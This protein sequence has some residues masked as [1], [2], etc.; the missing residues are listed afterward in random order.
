MFINFALASY[1]V[2]ERIKDISIEKEGEMKFFYF[3][4]NIAQI[5]LIPQNA[6]VTFSKE[7]Q[8]Q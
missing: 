7:K 8:K 3:R 1:N 5:L 4:K 2:N 6:G